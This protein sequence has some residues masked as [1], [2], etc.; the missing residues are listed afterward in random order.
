M[1]PKSFRAGSFAKR[2][3]NVKESDV[4]F[5]PFFATLSAKLQL[6]TAKVAFRKKVGIILVAEEAEM[7]RDFWNKI[8]GKKEKIIYIYIYK[9]R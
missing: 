3:F 8:K 1:T 9:E 6:G 7:Q 2:V 5:L 4:V